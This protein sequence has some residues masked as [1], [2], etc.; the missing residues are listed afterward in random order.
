MT[1]TQEFQRKPDY[2]DSLEASIQGSRQREQTNPRYRNFKQTHFTAGDEEQFQR[3]RD[4]R[5]GSVCTREIDLSENIYPL[6]T[7][8]PWKKYQDLRANAVINTFR[9]IFNKFKKG[10]FIKIVNNKLVVFLP[11]SKA[12]FINEWSDKIAVD[13]SKYATVNEFIRHISEMEGRPFRPKFINGNLDGW[14]ANNCL[15]RYEYPISEGES[16][17]HSVKNMFEE[18][19][20]TRTVPDVEFFYNRRDFPLLTRDGTEPYNNIWGSMEKLLVSHNYEQ[21]L[22]ILSMCSTARYADIRSVTWEDWARV[23]RKEGIFFP[24]ANHDYDDNF[25][26]PWN[27]KVPTAVFRGGSTGCGVTINDNPRLKVAWMS[28]QGATDED[29][30]PF[31]NAG[32]TNWNLRP[33]KLQNSKYLQTIEKDSLPFGLVEKLTPQEQSRFKYIINLDGHVTAFRLSL[34]LSMGSVILLADSPWK[35]WY[36]DMLNPYEHYVPVK[37]DLSDLIDQIKWCKQNDE[38]CK[39]IAK[40]ARRFYD[41]YLSKRGILDYMQKLLVEMRAE[42]GTYLYNVETPLDTL[43]ESEYAS[44]DYSYPDIPYGIEEIHS[45]PLIGRSYGL[46]KGVEWMVRK[47]IQEGIFTELAS[48]GESLFTNKLGVI[49]KYQVAG[50]NFAVKQT[51]DSAKIKEHIHEAYVGTHSTNKLLKYVPNF[52]YIF[53]LFKDGETYN[54]ITELI[55]GVSLSEYISSSTFD[56]GEFL[57]ILIQLA[58][59]LQVGQNVCGLVHYDLTPWNIVIQRLKKPITFEYALSVDNVVRISTSVI[60]VIIDFGKS[61]VIHEDIHH[62]FVNMFKTSAIQD[63]ISLILSSVEQ[64]VKTQKLPKQDFSSL[65]HLMNFLSG[66]EYCPKRFTNAYSIREFIRTKSKYYNL[67][68]DEKYELEQKSPLNFVQYIL[69]LNRYY[70]FKLSKINPREYR[71]LMN[72]GNPR[73]VYEYIFAGT[74]EERIQSYMNVFIRLKHCSI[75]QPNNLFFVYYAVQQLEINLK[76][77]RDSMLFYLKREKINASKYEK[78]YRETVR[79]LKRVY[80]EHIDNI[81]EQQ[82]DYHLKTS[83]SDVLVKPYSESDF[84]CPRRVETLIRLYNE[85]IHIDLSEYKQIVMLT[86][87]NNGSYKLNDKDREYYMRNFEPLLQTSSLAMKIDVA[88]FKTL[89]WM[90]RKLYGQN[91]EW[92]TSE[93]DKISE[94]EVYNCSEAEKYLALYSNTLNLANSI[95]S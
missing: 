66:T 7:F 42:T 88:N 82:V 69:Q 19:C 55:Q 52:A 77:V 28:S 71:P 20:A 30:I 91:I 34:E 79:F 36:R 40:N 53:G 84:L 50:F 61:H 38:Q 94:K 41:V 60:P 23:Q 14:Y 10:V 59:A 26:T 90:T 80:T 16:N 47:I 11:F 9:Y 63:V 62:G 54:V 51:S 87:I 93:L 33:R 72:R 83:Y 65:F 70:K 76:S 4:E 48:G 27:E 18:L 24:R 45:L 56:M 17:I 44:L 25:N 75:P 81:E 29:G 1:T 15:V 74:T 49:R 22:P 64:I 32:I 37:E 31:L 8:R 43:I 5:N 39:Q 21:Y 86:L 12:K 3:Y 73:Q 95:D 67:V 58:L 46:L 13:K 35:I 68:H 78:I 92:L 2:Y 6:P 85:S 89:L 57:F